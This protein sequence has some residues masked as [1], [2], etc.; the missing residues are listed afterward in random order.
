[1]LAEEF[2]ALGLAQSVTERMAGT[3]PNVTAAAQTGQQAVV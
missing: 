1:M 3:R 2:L